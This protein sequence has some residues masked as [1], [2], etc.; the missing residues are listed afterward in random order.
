[1]KSKII[2]NGILRAI[3]IILGLSLFLYFLFQIRSVIVYIIIAA[4][5]SLIGRPIIRFLKHK[6]KFPNTLAVVSTMILFLGM[7]FGLISM[8]IPLIVKQS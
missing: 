6:L 1:M 4:V 3:G 5:L 7:L 2:T 8:F